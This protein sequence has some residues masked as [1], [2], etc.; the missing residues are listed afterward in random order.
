MPQLVIRCYIVLGIQVCRDKDMVEVVDVF[1]DKF[2]DIFDSANDAQAK[3]AKDDYFLQ[4]PTVQL[5][6]PE[7]NS[8]PESR[9]PSDIGA[10][11]KD[12]VCELPELSHVIKLVKSK[13]TPGPDTVTAEFLT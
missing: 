3:T 13:K 1:E 12:S 6:L 7:K 9:L 4:L 5:K 11:V 2:D 8:E 10:T